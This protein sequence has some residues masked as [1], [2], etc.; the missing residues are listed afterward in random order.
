MDSLYWEVLPGAEDSEPSHE[1]DDPCSANVGVSC[2]RCKNKQKL[3]RRCQQLHIK[4]EDVAKK[5]AV[6]NASQPD[7]A[8]SLAAIHAASPGSDTQLPEVVLPPRD[9]QPLDTAPRG[10]HHHTAAAPVYAAVY[11]A[12]PSRMSTYT[13]STCAATTHTCAPRERTTRKGGGGPAAPRRLQQPRRPE[14]R[15]QRSRR[16]GAGTSGGSVDGWEEADLEGGSYWAV[17]G[18]RWEE[19]EVREAASP[20]K[21]FQ[22]RQQTTVTF[23]RNRRKVVQ[24]R[25]RVDLMRNRT[26]RSRR[27]VDPPPP[28]IHHDVLMLRALLGRGYMS[29]RGHSRSVFRMAYL[30]GTGFALGPW[31]S[32]GCGGSDFSVC[33]FI[34]RECI[35]NAVFGWLYGTL[36]IGREVVCDMDEVD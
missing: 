26:A 34:W 32:S 13:S 22:Q 6:E 12:S 7:L 1:E 9:E 33:G 36:G 2:A 16:S 15:G 21:R 11:T 35:L 17:E 24:R 4:R 23:R 5:S 27:L 8:A 20:R 14:R 19:Q 25:E 30:R 28:R 31:C 10:H 29:E 3:C 18:A